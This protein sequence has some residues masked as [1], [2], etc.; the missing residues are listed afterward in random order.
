MENFNT[1]MKKILLGDIS[2][3]EPIL[4][5]ITNTT[6]ESL[7][8]KKYLLKYKNI[9]ESNLLESLHSI[10]DLFRKKFHSLYNNNELIVS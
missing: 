5:R 2:I 6:S 9:N 8:F 10:S 4:V 3:H 1:F 7:P